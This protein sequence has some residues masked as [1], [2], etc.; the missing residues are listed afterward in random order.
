[1]AVYDVNAS[2][3]Q[4]QKAQSPVWPFRLDNQTYELP[5]ELTRSTARQLRQ[6]EDWDVDGLLKLLLG[7]QQYARFEKHQTT[8]QDIAAL[9]EAYG[10]ETGLGLDGRQS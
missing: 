5:V 1:M 6:L 4:R 10:K 7:E 2:R 3:D 9:L 8:M